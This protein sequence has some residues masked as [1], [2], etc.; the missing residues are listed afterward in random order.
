M[1]KGYVPSVFISSTCYD[2]SQVRIDLKK[3]VETFG[4]EPVVSESFAFPV[5]PHSD[6]VENCLRVVKDR[7]DIFVLIVGNRYGSQTDTG[8]SITNLEYLEARAKGIPIYVFVLKAILQIM[9]VWRKNRE[10]DYSDIVD[11]PKLFEF[12]EEVRNAKDHWLFGFEEASQIGETLQKQL[13][14][15]F[16]DALIVREKVRDLPLPH[17]LS[18]L[19]GRSLRLVM[20]KPAGWE[21]FLFASVLDDGFCKSADLKWDL[22]YSLKTGGVR[23]FSTSEPGAD[24]LA[25]TDWIQGK[26]KSIRALVDTASTLMNTAIQ[27]AMGPLE[28]AGDSQHIVYVARRL[29]QVHRSLLEWAIDCNDVEVRPQCERAIALIATFANDVLHKLESIPEKIQTEISK[30]LEAKQKGETYKTEIMIVLD[31]P[32]TNE[33]AEELE[34]IQAW[35]A[36]QV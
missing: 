36:E 35:I 13:A 8:R 17:S 30:A 6:V 11:T 23:S 4:L 31:S 20:E 32:P 29:A 5:D 33:F 9:P 22:K 27:E 34:K 14:Y 28:V 3:S 26:F 15:L 10:S 16:M 7:A 18:E 24:L 12:V 21:F 19:A 25:M 2:L 1:P